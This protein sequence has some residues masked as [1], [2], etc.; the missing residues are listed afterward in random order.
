MT[1]ENKV[2]HD[3]AAHYSMRYAPG[4]GTAY[5][6]HLFV[7]PDGVGALVVSNFAKLRPF[8]FNT[9]YFAGARV[10]GIC[11]DMECHAY[12]TGCDIAAALDLLMAEHRS[13]S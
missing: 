6:C 11:D 12:A 1:P 4:N 8:Y 10:F 7:T 3:A 9:R 2:T 13:R 5:D